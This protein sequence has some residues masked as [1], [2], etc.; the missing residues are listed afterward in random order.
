MS[1]C[2]L[3]LVVVVV[4]EVLLVTGETVEAC[5]FS[6][7]LHRQNNTFSKHSLKPWL[8]NTHFCE[9]NNI[10]KP[11]NYKVAT[12]QSYQRDDIRVR[13]QRRLQTKEGGK[14]KCYL[15]PL[16]WLSDYSDVMADIIISALKA[17]MGFVNPATVRNKQQQN[18]FTFIIIQHSI[19]Q[20]HHLR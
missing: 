20:S 13:L 8:H 10:N 2:S 11:V 1:I 15:L 9:D 14:V 4:F 3:D 7:N 19:T 17:V 5:I 18:S 16:T 6:N 12:L